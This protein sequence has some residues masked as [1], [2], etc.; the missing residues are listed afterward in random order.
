MSKIPEILHGRYGFIQFYDYP[1]LYFIIII[2]IIMDYSV[3]GLTACDDEFR[4]DD[5]STDV[6]VFFGLYIQ[7]E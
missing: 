6:L 7:I 2:I 4:G 3:L 5:L 1:N